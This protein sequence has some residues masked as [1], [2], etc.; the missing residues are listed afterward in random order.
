MRIRPPLDPAKT[1]SNVWLNL[2]KEGFF[3]KGSPYFQAFAS[4]R[5]STPTKAVIVVPSM[6]GRLSVMIVGNSVEMTFE[7]NNGAF[8]HTSSF[9]FDSRRRVKASR[10]AEMTLKNAQVALDWAMSRS[11][12]I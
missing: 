11:H 12:W 1:L 6:K 8:R 4:F 3:S 2:I 10:L 7:S 9:S 5:E